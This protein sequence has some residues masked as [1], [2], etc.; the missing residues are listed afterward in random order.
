MINNY[1]ENKLEN[2]KSQIELLKKKL[3]SIDEI[4]SIQE[5]ALDLID[6]KSKSLF[7]ESQLNNN[8]SPEEIMK[9]IFKTKKLPDILLK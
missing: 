8:L 2:I 6:E 7:I 1:R 4:L 3:N 9:N 5:K